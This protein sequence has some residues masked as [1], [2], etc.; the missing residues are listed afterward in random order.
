MA[1]CNRD[2]NKLLAINSDGT[3]DQVVWSS[4]SA[5]QT[6]YLDRRA[7]KLYAGGFSRNLY[8]WDLVTGEKKS[9]G[10]SL[11]IIGITG[12]DRGRVFGTCYNKPASL[13]DMLADGGALTQYGHRLI[14]NGGYSFQRLCF[15]DTT[16]PTGSVL[17]FR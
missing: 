1:V 5:I 7:R 12:D 6:L 13:V 10:G 15:F 9:K 14:L 16:P 8:C 17:I 11:D 4:A 2:A 3:F